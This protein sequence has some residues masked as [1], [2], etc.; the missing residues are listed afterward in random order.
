MN[1]NENLDYRR[2]HR[3]PTIHQMN[4]DGRL[5]WEIHNVSN[6]IEYLGN[7]IWADKKEFKLTGPDCLM[8]YWHNQHCQERSLE[9]R[10]SFGDSFMLW[11]CF[12]GSGKCKCRGRAVKGYD[13]LKRLG[14]VVAI[15]FILLS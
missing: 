6:T 4:H 11:G 3:A 15:V 10:H 14:R 5:Q 1:K 9:T 13:V 7:I 8:F 12:T 2:M